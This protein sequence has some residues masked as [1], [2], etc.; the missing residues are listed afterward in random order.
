MVPEPQNGVSLSIEPVRAQNV[1]CGASVLKTVQFDDKSFCSTN[2]V[3][4]IRA[5]WHLPH[6]FLAVQLPVP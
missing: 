1:M 5:D 4:K 6:E 2:E 3:C